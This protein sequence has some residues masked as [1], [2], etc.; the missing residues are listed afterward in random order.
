MRNQLCV[1]AGVIDDF[2]N[3]MRRI[4]I[5]KQYMMSFYRINEDHAEGQSNSWPYGLNEKSYDLEEK[6]LKRTRKIT[7]K[8]TEYQ[9][10]K[11]DE[12]RTKTASRLTRKS[13]MIEEIFYSST[14]QCIFS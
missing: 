4:Q 5:S 12:R 10:S 14:H 8:S 2:Q 7:E 13:G 3:K 11:L 6:P 1:D 9:P